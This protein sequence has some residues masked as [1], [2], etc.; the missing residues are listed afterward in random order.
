MKHKMKLVLK[1]VLKGN[2]Q[3]YSLHQKKQESSQIRKLILKLKELEKR[4]LNPKL[5]EGRDK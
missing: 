4:K 2:V 5:V 1:L 3:L